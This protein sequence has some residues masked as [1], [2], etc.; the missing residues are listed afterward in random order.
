MLILSYEFRIRV[1][2]HKIHCHGKR[3]RYTK[4]RK[5]GTYQNL[6]GKKVGEKNQKGQ[7]IGSDL[8]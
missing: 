3:S 1:I 2:T 5:K 4:E 7:E 8:L 6:K